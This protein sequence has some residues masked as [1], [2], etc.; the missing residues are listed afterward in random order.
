MDDATVVSYFVV[1][2]SDNAEKFRTIGKV[3]AE[4]QKRFQL[5]DNEINKEVNYYRIKS[6]E[7]YGEVSYSNILAL[8]AKEYSLKSTKIFPNPANESINMELEK[9]DFTNIQ[10]LI[11]TVKSIV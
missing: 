9:G 5:I 11:L 7:P 6:F 1:T 4:N 3:L 2:K 8:Q 10:Y